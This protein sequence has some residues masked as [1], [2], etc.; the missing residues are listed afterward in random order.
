MVY[1]MVAVLCVDTALLV[2]TIRMSLGAVHGII[3]KCQVR[4]QSW[5]AYA[6]IRI[7]YLSL[8]LQEPLLIAMHTMAKVEDQFS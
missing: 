7:N 3:W 5:V 1:T 6:K 4:M 8:F 2:T